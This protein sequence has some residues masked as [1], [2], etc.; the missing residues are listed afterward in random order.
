MVYVILQT[1]FMCGNKDSISAIG[2]QSKR[3]FWN[4]DAEFYCPNI[5]VVQKYIG[6]F[7]E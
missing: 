6:L 7:L 5:P 4:M 2:L 1:L 3:V